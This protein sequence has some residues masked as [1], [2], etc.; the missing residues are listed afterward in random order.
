VRKP[1][2]LTAPVSAM[3]QLTAAGTAAVP[4]VVRGRVAVRRP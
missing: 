2:E 4:T 3:T 1:G